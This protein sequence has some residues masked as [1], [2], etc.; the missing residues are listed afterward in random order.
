MKKFLFVLTAAAVGDVAWIEIQ[1][2]GQDR[3]V[4][5]EVTDPVD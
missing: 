5:Q 2:K 1:K 4:W 3:A